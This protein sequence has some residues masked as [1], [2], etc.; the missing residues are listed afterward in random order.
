MNALDRNTGWY[1]LNGQK[2]NKPEH[3]K[4]IFIRDGKKYRY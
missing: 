4:G 1:H 3:G 2:V